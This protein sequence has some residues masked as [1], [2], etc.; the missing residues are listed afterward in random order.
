MLEK[1]T[2]WILSIMVENVYDEDVHIAHTIPCK[3]VNI[4][5]L[6]T[7]KMF[8]ILS[9]EVNKPETRLLIKKKIITPVINMFYTEL[10]PY[11]IGMIVIIV[12]ILV[13]SLFT[14]ISFVVYYLKKL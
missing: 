12:M 2:R 7:A 4:G 13:L 9:D 10:Y 3:T 6:L 8:S 5:K 11:I 14:F 1:I